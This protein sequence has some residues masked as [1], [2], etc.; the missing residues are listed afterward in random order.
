MRRILSTA[1]ALVVFLPVVLLVSC[2]GKL[3][4][5]QMVSATEPEVQ[6]APENAVADVEQDERQID[7]L[8]EKTIAREPVEPEFVNE[9]VH[10]AFDS[11]ELSYQARQIL[12]SMADHLRTNTDITVTIEGHCDERGTDAYNIAL[13]GQRAESAKIFLVDLG[14][15]AERIKTVSYGKKQ[16]IAVGH[17]EDS[18]SINRRAEFVIN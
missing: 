12:N 14:I 3:D 17:T 11:F 16:P 6:K 13:G 2:T 10:F 9:N 7:R 4:R 8:Q 5:T 1:V 18:W 15:D